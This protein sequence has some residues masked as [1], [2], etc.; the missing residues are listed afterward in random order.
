MGSAYGV[1]IQYS[2]EQSP[3]ETAG[4]IR[5]ALPLLGDDNFAIV[6]SDVWTD[7]PFEQLHQHAHRACHLV[8]I[9]NPPQHLQGDFYLRDQQLRTDPPGQRLTYSGIGIY[10]PSLFKDVVP[11]MKHPLRPCLQ[12]AIN[13][14][15]ATG[16]HYHGVWQDIGTPERLAELRDSAQQAI[17]QNTVNTTISEANVSSGE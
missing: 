12:E 16:E 2:I 14:D 10:H 9:T 17:R 1:S 7:Y 4:G 11:G 13:T 8:M 6:N 15:T 5:H 3:L